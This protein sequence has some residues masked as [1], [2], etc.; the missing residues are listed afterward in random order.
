MQPVQ[1]VNGEQ[2]KPVYI[3]QRYVGEASR[4]AAHQT[5]I[6][7]QVVRLPRAK[8]G[9]VLLPERWVVERSFA[10]VSRSRRLAYD[11][12]P[13][14]QTPAGMAFGADVGDRAH[15]NRTYLSAKSAEP[16][17]GKLDQYFWRRSLGY[18]RTSSGKGM[19]FE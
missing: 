8:S 5:G 1:K 7:L 19:A 2:V 10:W 13:L 12:N 4:Q 18:G 14:T 11:Y 16:L 9:F 3:Y 6:D 17:L 15:P